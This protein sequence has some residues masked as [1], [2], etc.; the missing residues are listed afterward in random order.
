MPQFSVLGGKQGSIPIKYQATNTGS[1]HMIEVE[2][3]KQQARL[4]VYN[5]RFCS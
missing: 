2:I 4:D 1:V 5:Y 3:H